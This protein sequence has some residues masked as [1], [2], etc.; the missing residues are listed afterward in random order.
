MRELECFR[1][2]DENKYIVWA[3]T[4][5]HFRC[6][7]MI[8]Y[9]FSELLQQNKYV[10]LNFFCEKHGKNTRDQHFALVSNWIKRESFVKRLCNSSDIVNAIHKQQLISNNNNKKLYNDSRKASTKTPPRP[11]AI[12]KAF[13]IPDHLTNIAE[14][15]YRTIDSLCS[16]YNIFN[17]NNIDLKTRFMSDNEYYEILKYKDHSKN[18]PIQKPRRVDQVYT[19][20]PNSEGLH[21]KMSSWE[22]FNNK[23]PKISRSQL[24]SADDASNINPCIDKNYKHCERT[25]CNNCSAICR[26]RLS[27]LTTERWTHSSQ[28][29]KDELG[30]HGHPMSRGRIVRC[31][32]MPRTIDEAKSE[33]YNHYITYHLNQVN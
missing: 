21:S 10:S 23:W 7:E 5:P 31:K 19:Q 33:L 25:K 12:T 13:V 8:H 11:I 30:A 27:D 22:Y 32:K 26:I 1:E 18:D 16:Y 6:A 4:G 28:K 15:N 29:L 17:D 9:L 3:D 2:I 24:N 20:Q 14:K